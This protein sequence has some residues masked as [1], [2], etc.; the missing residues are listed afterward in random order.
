MGRLIPSM[1]Q[2]GKEGSK[3]NINYVSMKLYVTSV[4]GKTTVKVPPP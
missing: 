2:A 3:W 4:G 1:D